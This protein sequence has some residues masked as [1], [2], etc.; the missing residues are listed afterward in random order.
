M[1]LLPLQKYTNLKNKLADTDTKG[2]RKMVNVGG[3]TYKRENRSKK[4]CR[5]EEYYRCS[6]W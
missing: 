1:V 5:I 2:N 4:E 3:K 6:N